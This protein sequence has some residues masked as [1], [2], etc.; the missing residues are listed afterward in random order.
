MHVSYVVMYVVMHVRVASKSV[1]RFQNWFFLRI[2]ELF[3]YVLSMLCLC[4]A[5]INYLKILCVYYSLVIL[6]KKEKLTFVDETKLAGK[7]V[8]EV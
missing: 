1:K 8:S 6:V 5:L 4:F 2:S 7:K 3:F